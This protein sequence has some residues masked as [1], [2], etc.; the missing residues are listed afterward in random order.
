MSQEAE[1]PRVS[2]GEIL[3]RLVSVGLPLGAVFAFFSLVASGPLLNWVTTVFLMSAIAF[4][5]LTRSALAKSAE[6]PRLSVFGFL[7]R[8]LAR[9][10]RVPLLTNPFTLRV[11]GAV[12]FGLVVATVDWL[13]ATFIVGTW[14]MSADLTGLISLGLVLLATYFAVFYFRLRRDD[15]TPTM[16]DELS[17]EY[18]E[19]RGRPLPVPTLEL[20]PWMRALFNAAA[21]TL[22]TV[23]VRAFAIWAMPLLFADWRGGLSFLLTLLTAAVAPEYV[24]WVWRKVVNRIETKSTHHSDESNPNER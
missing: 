8:V 10:L 14:G 24:V 23:I 12:I 17:E 3:G 1:L 15:G 19:W 18:E 9:L 7:L 21:Q 22:V 11:I 5:T 20:E 13:V 6:E 2:I 4:N 16:W